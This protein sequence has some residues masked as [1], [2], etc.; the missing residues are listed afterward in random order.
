MFLELSASHLQLVLYTFT[1]PAGC[2]ETIGQMDSSPNV[3]G[4]Q[5]KG[6]VFVSESVT[7]TKE[8]SVAHGVFSR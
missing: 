4:V 2:A 6:V 3:R 1:P 7:G 5:C 8:L